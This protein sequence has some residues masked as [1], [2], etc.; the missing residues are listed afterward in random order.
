MG[1]FEKLPH[2]IRARLWGITKQTTHIPLGKA[3]YIELF[4]DLVFVFCIQ[5]IL[6]LITNI[7]GDVDWYSY[8][9]FWFIKFFIIINFFVFIIIIILIII[10]F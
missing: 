6:P 4:F 7:E 10:Y 8:Y 1:F 9:T 5:S 3:S 2:K